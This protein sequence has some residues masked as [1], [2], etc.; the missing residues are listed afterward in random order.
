MEINIEINIY[1]KFEVVLYGDKYRDKYKY[2]EKR[3]IQALEGLVGLSFFW[4]YERATE[5]LK[6][7]RGKNIFGG[8][9]GIGFGFTA[10]ILPGRQL[11]SSCCSLQRILLFRIIHIKYLD[12]LLTIK[13]M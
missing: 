4:R 9:V 10:G 11:W 8:H 7:D 5:Q 1:S 2:G 13:I 3:G 6:A 12:W